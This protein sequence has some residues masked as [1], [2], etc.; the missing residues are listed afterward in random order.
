M[1]PTRT[2]ATLLTLCLTLTFAAST[3]AAQKHRQ[4]KKKTR[5]K[6]ALVIPAITYAQHTEAMRFALELERSAGWEPGWAQHWL[7]QAQYLPTV[8]RLV[9]PAAAGVAKNWNAYCERFVEPRRIAA[10]V[11]FWQDNAS[12]LQRAQTEY[13][14]PAWL[15][16][17]IIGVETLYGQHTGQF[18]TLDA[19]ATLSFD[20]P[21]EHPRATQRA[22]YFRTELEALLRL[23]HS[24]DTT[25]ADWRGSYAG[26]LG[27]PQFMP[28]NW[29]KLGVD[30]DNDGH[31]DLLG[32]PADAIGSVANYMRSFGW[33]A[34]LPTHYAVKLKA[35]DEQMARLL[36]PDILP[37]F[38]LD[39]LPELG[40]HPVNPSP[41]HQGLLALVKLDNGDPTQG[42]AAPTY[43]LGTQNF[44]AVTRY[45]WSSYYAMAVITLGQ[46]VEASLAGDDAPMR[47]NQ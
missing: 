19:L 45:N 36:G 3:E 10:G 4:K 37:S 39:T 7:A 15:I 32:S 21:A 13:G 30:F 34:G 11:R 29:S 26:A 43:V 24:S 31:T 20:F 42:G 25:P 38:E 5:A 27:L 9:T 41:Q 14:V 8:V 12:A 46:A 1:T 16:V 47:C 18:R 33:Q 17:G 35:D 2:L 40:A 22:A 23:A 6:P 28:S 44:Y